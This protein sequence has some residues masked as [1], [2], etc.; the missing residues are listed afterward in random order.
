MT[1]GHCDSAQVWLNKIY[2][3]VSY[4]RPSLFSYY[5]TTRQA[6]LY[7]YNNLHELGILEANKAE[8]IALVL[9]DSLL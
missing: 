7:Y 2:L 9:K 8:N 3:K 4:R 5:L 1:D 6:G